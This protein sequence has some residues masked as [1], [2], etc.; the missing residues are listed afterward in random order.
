MGKYSK[1]REKL[2]DIQFDHDELNEAKTSLKD[3]WADNWPFRL[4]VVGAGGAVLLLLI[5]LAV[6]LG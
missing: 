5:A 1:V 3:L 2:R 4:A 6:S